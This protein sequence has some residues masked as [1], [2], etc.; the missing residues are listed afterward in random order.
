MMYLFYFL[1]KRVSARKALY[2]Y[3]CTLLNKKNKFKILRKAGVT[4]DASCTITPPFT[5]GEGRLTIDKNVFINS[6]CNC[7][8]AEKITIGSNT[9]IGPNVT[10]TTITHKTSPQSR[11]NKLITAPIHIGENVWI[12][13]GVTILPGV[14]VGKGSVIGANSIVNC[15]IPDNTMFAGNPAIFK[16]NL[17]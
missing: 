3:N 6:N 12:G 16:K 9:L 7:I 13:A 11:H 15:D 5:F 14:S 4:I 2:V 1:Q 8:D 17:S 10:I